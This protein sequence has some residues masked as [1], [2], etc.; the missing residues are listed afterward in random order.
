[1]VAQIIAALAILAVIGLYLVWLARRL[2]RLHARVDTAAAG[3]DAQLARRRREIA[4]FVSGTS[5]PAPFGERL[6]GAVAGAAAVPGLG[7]DREVAEN[8]LMRALAAAAAA[9]PESFATTA[10]DEVYDENVRARLARGFYNDAVRDAL[11][12]RD[13]RVV[14]WLRLAG[15]AAHPAYFEAVDDD[16][17]L[18]AYPVASDRRIEA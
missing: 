3:L 1:V 10:V 13:R 11:V 17:P 18:P 14:R 7:P 15:R 9:A 16:L 12:V 6:E 5:L 8:A 4:A 2:D